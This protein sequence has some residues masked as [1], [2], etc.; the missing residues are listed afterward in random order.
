MFIVLYW[1][2]MQPDIVFNFTMIMFL[3]FSTWHILLI[4]AYTMNN[5]IIFS[6]YSVGSKREMELRNAAQG[7]LLFLQQNCICVLML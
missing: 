7:I 3:L 5:K 1:I 4:L 2:V 6:I